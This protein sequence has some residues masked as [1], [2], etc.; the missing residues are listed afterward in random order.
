MLR[1]YSGTRRNSES[2]KE[3]E[4]ANDAGNALPAINE[5][6]IHILPYF[7]ITPPVR[8]SSF[9]NRGRA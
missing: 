4:K 3:G 1:G 8:V 6:D 7:W 2:H 5:M 9:R